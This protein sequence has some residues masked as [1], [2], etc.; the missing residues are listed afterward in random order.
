MAKKFTNDNSGEFVP[1]SQFLAAS[2]DDDLTVAKLSLLG[3]VAE[4]SIE[5]PDSGGL[6]LAELYAG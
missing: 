6:T 4:L 5:K 2:L 1:Q 3:K